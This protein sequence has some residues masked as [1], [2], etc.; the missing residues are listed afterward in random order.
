MRC[1]G[2]RFAEIRA[3]ADMASRLFIDARRFLSRRDE[4]IFSALPRAR[5]AIRHVRSVRPRSREAAKA[6]DIIYARTIS[7]RNY[8]LE[9]SCAFKLKPAY[10]FGWFAAAGSA[11]DITG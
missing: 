10:A 1:A 6:T 2:R 7:G 3:S 5:R 4:P 9:T 8:C 11:A